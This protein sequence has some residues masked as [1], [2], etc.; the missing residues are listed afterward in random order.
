MM[1]RLVPA[2]DDQPA[3][4]AAVREHAQQDVRR[5]ASWCAVGMGGVTPWQRLRG[6]MA[7]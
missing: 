1:V 5:R 2:G 6:L 3:D 4:A 7:A